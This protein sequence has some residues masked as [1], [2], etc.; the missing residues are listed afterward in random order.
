MP[1]LRKLWSILNR[2]DKN[3]VRCCDSRSAS[4]ESESTKRACDGG[5]EASIRG[6]DHSETSKMEDF[7]SSAQEEVDIF[8]VSFCFGC[9]G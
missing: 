7:N 3:L 1:R 8:S 5:V 2:D 4:L 9:T 6:D